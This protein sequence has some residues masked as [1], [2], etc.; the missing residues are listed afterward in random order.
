MTSTP[1]PT[2]TPTIPPNPDPICWGRV[3][4]ADNGL[5]IREVPWGEIIGHVFTGDIL[6]FDAKWYLDFWWYRIEWFDDGD[7][8]YISSN[9]VELGEGADCSE[10]EDVT[11]HVSLQGAHVIAAN[12]ANTLLNYC[13]QLATIKL[14]ESVMHY[15][16][17]FRACN[18]DIWILCRYWT[19]D[20]AGDTDYN[21]ELSYQRIGGKFPDDCDGVEWENEKAPTTT[22]NWER[23]SQ[24]SID[25]AI[26]MAERRNMQYCAFSL[27]PGWPAFDKV[28]YMVEYI[29]WVHDNPLPDGRYHCISSHASMYAPW[30][31]AD[32]PWVNEPFIAGRVYKIRD[33][34]YATS[35]DHFDLYEWNGVWSITE[36]GLSDGYSG[37]WSAPYTCDE[38]KS[39]YWETHD[40]YTQY[41]FPDVQHHWNFGKAGIWTDDSHCAGAIWG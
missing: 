12:G 32:M 9:Y 30:S 13:A 3:I 10:L 7:P 8:G 25:A 31:R 39:A 24:Y 34:I 18:P 27:G 14:F 16:D 17:D 20:I 11:P 35:G 33:W 22:R 37:N 23:W 1:S 26:L 29:R 38:L 21:A 40:T 4:K 6:A 41:E 2:V 5:R 28:Q 15:A 19:D 36:V